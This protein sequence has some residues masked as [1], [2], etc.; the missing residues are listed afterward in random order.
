MTDILDRMCS[1]LRDYDGNRYHTITVA[2]QIWTV[3]NLRTTHYADGTAIPL[4]TDNT[5]WQADTTGAMCWYDNNKRNK[6]RYGA[7]Y[8]W[9]AVDNA[10]GLPYF[11]R[12]GVQEATWHIPTAAEY[13]TLIAA[14]GATDVNAG[15]LLKEVG[16]VSWNYALATDTYGFRAVGAGNRFEDSHDLE[17]NGFANDKIYLDAWTADELNAT[18]ANSL[19]IM[20]LT[21]NFTDYSYN[22]NAGMSVRCVRAV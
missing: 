18:E 7:L 12:D 14:I 5:L 13:D 4:I 2:N 20:S 1:I 3:E 6:E 9:Y 8:N 17:V 21:T 15:G 19:Y 11:T 22:K 10:A 16:L